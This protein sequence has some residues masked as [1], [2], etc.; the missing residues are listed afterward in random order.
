VGVGDPLGWWA[1]F[2][3]K[4]SLFGRLPMFLLYSFA[5]LRIARYLIG[6]IFSRM[7]FLIPVERLYE[8]DTLL[9]F[10]H[11]H[12]SYLIHILLVPKKAIAS[13]MELDPSDKVFLADVFSTTQ[14]LVEE[15]DLVEPGF[16]LLV[17]GGEY[18]DVPQLHFHLVSG[19][20]RA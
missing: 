2:P 8:T 16:R 17:N 19:E 11:P 18:Q 12:P 10:Y 4:D 15:L 3:T 14:K 6:W 9:A 13:L 5:R 20:L 1:A 7:S